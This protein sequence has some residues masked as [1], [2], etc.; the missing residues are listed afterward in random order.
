MISTTYK[1][2]T[3]T[4]S[5]T[6][7]SPLTSSALTGDVSVLRQLAV[8]GAVV[9]P[10]AAEPVDAEQDVVVWTLDG[11]D[12]RL[13]GRHGGPDHHHTCTGGETGR[14]GSQLGPTVPG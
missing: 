13:A 8:D 1:E 7:C 10:V 3:C 9:E 12:S 5:C 6:S 4:A 11:P 2:G 14:A